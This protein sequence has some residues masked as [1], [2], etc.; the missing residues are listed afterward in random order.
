MKSI[1]VKYENVI[2]YT[3]SFDYDNVNASAGRYYNRLMYVNLEKDDRKLNPTRIE[4]GTSSDVYEDTQILNTEFNSVSY[5]GDFNGDGYDDIFS[6]PNTAYSENFNNN[7]LICKT[8]YN[9][10]NGGFTNGSDIIYTKSDDYNLFGVHPCDL[11]GDGL[12]D[13]ILHSVSRNEVYSNNS[14]AIYVSNGNSF[15]YKGNCNINYGHIYDE[16]DEFEYNGIFAG[17]FLG[18]GKSDIL[19]IYNTYE[20]SFYRLLSFENDEIQP[21]ISEAIISTDFVEK[22][23]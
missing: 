18:R 13:L 20:G 14:L 21:I 17:D 6:V 11:N 15:S 16:E 3:Y 9:N 22:K 1:D 8:L 12:C 23:T 4:W 2:L 7:K 19:I 10:K 5:V